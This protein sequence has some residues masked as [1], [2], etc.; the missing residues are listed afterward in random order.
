MTFV[1][2]AV[3]LALAASLGG[4]MVGPNYKR[5]DSDL[6]PPYSE[7]AKAGPISVPQKWWT[8]YNDPLLDELIASGLERNADVREAAA[9]VE[10]AEAVVSPGRGAFFPA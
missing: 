7:P 9:R 4:C 8:L 5:P 6:P 2:R 10:E 3:A 1:K